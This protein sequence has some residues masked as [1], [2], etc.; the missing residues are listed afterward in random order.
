MNDQGNPT[1]EHGK[2]EPDLGAVGLR[3]RARVRA[4]IQATIR[5]RRRPRR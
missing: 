4:K 5:R 2:E 1:H 3:D